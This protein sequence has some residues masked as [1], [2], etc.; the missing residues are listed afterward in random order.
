MRATTPGNIIAETQVMAVGVNFGGT[1]PVVTPLYPDDKG[2]LKGHRLYASALA[3]GGLF[4][5][6]N[7]DCFTIVSWV[8]LQHNQPPETGLVGATCQFAIVP[9]T[10]AGGNGQAG[11]P[12]IVSYQ[13][14]PIQVMILTPA[15]DGPVVLPP[16]YGFRI[17]TTGVGVAEQVGATV[18]MEKYR[19]GHAGMMV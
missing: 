15:V 6:P 9:L 11:V 13:E 18:F 16:G 17:I 10:N 1:A 8:H 2:G 14:D 12:A 4:V 19:D 5:P 7:T 3:S